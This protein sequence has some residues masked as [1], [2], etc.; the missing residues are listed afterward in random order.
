MTH[1]SKS[2]SKQS[3]ITESAHWTAQSTDDFCYRITFDFARQIE[4]ALKPETQATLAAK[5]GVTP[6]RVSQMLNNPGGISLRTAVKYARAIGRKVALVL[7]DDGDHENN[8]G[9][10]NSEVFGRTWEQAGRPRDF[11]ELETATTA[12][13]FR[14]IIV[15]HKE[16]NLSVDAAKINP[17]HNEPKTSFK[18]RRPHH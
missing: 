12:G 6:G 5:L 14:H 7:Y 15:S 2:S 13:G 17:L 8:S 16:N 11:F 4:G 3:S 18:R 1:T 10:I 9:P